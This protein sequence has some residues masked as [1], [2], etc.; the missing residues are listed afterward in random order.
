V[1][2]LLASFL[3]VKPRSIPKHAPESKTDDIAGLLGMLRP[4]GV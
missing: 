4:D 1:H 3:G 2:I